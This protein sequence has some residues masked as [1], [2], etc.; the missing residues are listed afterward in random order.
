MHAVWHRF[1][2]TRIVSGG[3]EPEVTGSSFTN[4]WPFWTFSNIFATYDA[5]SFRSAARFNCIPNRST[6]NPTAAFLL[7]SWWNQLW[8]RRGR[9]FQWGI[10]SLKMHFLRGRL[11]N[12]HTSFATDI[13]C[14]R[15]I[16]RSTRMDST[17]QDFLDLFWDLFQQVSL[18]LMISKL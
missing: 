15:A 8:A 1:A 11:S 18:E 14:G 5:P 4:T 6:A 7:H 3:G 12:C 10:I 17:L 9:Q 13:R 2:E 16:A